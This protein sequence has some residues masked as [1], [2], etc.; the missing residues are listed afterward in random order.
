MIQ[1][2]WVIGKGKD[3]WKRAMQDQDVSSCF[4]RSEN[5]GKSNL[6]AI[7]GDISGKPQ[8]S[9]KARKWCT[10]LQQNCEGNGLMI[11]RL[12]H[13]KASWTPPQ[14][15]KPTSSSQ[16]CIPPQFRSSNERRW[17][18]E[19]ELSIPVTRFDGSRMVS[20]FAMADVLVW[21]W[22]DEAGSREVFVLPD[23]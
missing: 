19:Y 2:L 6:I 4:F 16:Q 10:R 17:Q 20:C 21:R 23:F 22:D 9:E 18:E 13:D 1:L 14:R 12:L 8:T 5:E 11:C 3:S 15:T 7:T